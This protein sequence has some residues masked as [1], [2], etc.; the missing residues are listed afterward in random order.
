M[1]AMLLT[2]GVVLVLTCASF[3]TYE[4]VT[5]H[6]GLVDGYTTRAKIIASNSTAA[7]AFQNEADAVDVLSALKT[8]GRIIEACIYDGQGKV[9]AKYPDDALSGA[10]PAGPGV[11]GYRDGYLEIFSP[12]LQGN[13]TVGT[14]YLRS[15]L[16]AL[17]DR[18]SAYAWLSAAII[19]GS[20]LVAYLLARV[21]QRQISL[22]I[23]ALAETARAISSHRDFSVR[24][25]KFG[26]DELGLLTDAFNQML[27][28]ILDQDRALNEKTRLLDSVLQNMSEGIVVADQSGKMIYFNKA[29]ERIIG[30]GISENHS[31]EW[32]KEFGVYKEDGATPFREEELPLYKTVRGETVN[33]VV[34]FLRNQGH[35]DGIYISVNGNPI[36]N[37]KGV[38]EGG[39][40]VI[41]D[42]SLSR[43][44]EEATR[45]QDFITSVLENVPNMIFVK[46]AK[47]LR[48]V[49]FNK[50]GEELIGVPRKEL[51]G[52]NDYDLF[53]KDQADFFTS[54]DRKTMAGGKLLDIPEEPLPTKHQGERILHT[55]KIP[56]LDQAGNPQFLLGISEDITDQK[57]QQEMEMYTRALEVSNREMSDFVFVASHDLQEPLRKIQ[58][59]GEFLRDEFKETLGEAGR[60]YVERMQSAAKRMQILINDLL[61]LTRVTTKAQPFAPVD[62]NQVLKEVL[63]DLETRIAESKGKVEVSPLPTLRADATQMRQL[64]QNLISNALK[65]HKNDLPPLVKISA[66]EIKSGIARCRIRVEDNGIGFDNQYAEQIFKVFERLHGRGE[67]EGTGIGLAI[68]KKVVERHNGTIK[69]EGILG[70]GCIFTIEMP[71]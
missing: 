6:K 20:I 55:K 23:L 57:R 31:A 17:T 18:Y 19:A 5:L 37:S 53:P 7:L 38:I 54:K 12:V 56:V 8:D 59:F 62:L 22:P 70:K 47:D 13:R 63:V 34:Q 48:F 9:F 60:D 3:V 64:F 42:I 44:L 25:Q 40:V 36:R 52:K 69:A 35:P 26:E 61:A 39:L 33:D 67:Y 46:D 15:N 11:S 68:C 27:A 30:R 1:M 49:M 32:T 50:A 28:E 4:I 10:F 24:A 51:I 45:T 41:R 58:S 71:V 65:F 29:A 2:S 14:V 21:L 16:S 66:E 43:Q